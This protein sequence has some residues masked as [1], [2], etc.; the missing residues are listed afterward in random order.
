MVPRLFHQVDQAGQSGLITG[1]GD[2]HV[3][4]AMGIDSAREDFVTRTFVSRD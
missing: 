2:A 3:Q 4:Q 1:V